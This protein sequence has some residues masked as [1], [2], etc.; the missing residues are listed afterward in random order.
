MLPKKKSK[1]QKLKKQSRKAQTEKNTRN[2][3][4]I[5]LNKPPKVQHNLPITKIQF[6]IQ[7]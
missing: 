6:Q 5:K 1:M 2:E 3:K 7:S 4:T